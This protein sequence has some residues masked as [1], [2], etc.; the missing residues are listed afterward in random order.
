MICKEIKC[1]ELDADGEPAWCCWAGC[2]A[3]AAIAKCTAAAG[4]IQTMPGKKA[5]KGA[6]NE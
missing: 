5:S 4:H 2:P 6:K 3:K 1:P